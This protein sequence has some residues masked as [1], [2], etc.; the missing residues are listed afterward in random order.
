MDTLDIVEFCSDGKSGAPGDMLVGAELRKAQDFGPAFFVV[1]QGG[2]LKGFD[3]ADGVGGLFHRHIDIAD[4]L[5]LHGLYISVG[6]QP[7]DGPP[8]GV[9]GASVG[10]N[11][12]VFR[13]QQFPTGKNFLLYLL[14]QVF[15]YGF[16]FA[17]W[18]KDIP[19]LFKHFIF[20]HLIKNGSESQAC[21]QSLLFRVC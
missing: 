16:I 8:H 14:F 12:P 19:I 4:T 11:Q 20:L 7:G 3:A 5:P 21:I 15:V 17:L 6:Y 2:L 10:L 9:S 18:H 1:S 13:G